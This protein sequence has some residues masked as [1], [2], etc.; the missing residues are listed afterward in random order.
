[1][2][3]TFNTNKNAP[4]I[5]AKAAAQMFKDSLHF[6][7]SI[8]KAPA[9]DYKGKNG[10]SAGDTILISKPARTVPGSSFDITSAIQDTVEE[11]V[12]LTL[13]VISTIGLAADTPDFA[14]EIDIARYVERVVR[15]A[16]N[17][18][19]H[20]V[21]SKFLN[22]ATL[23]T[24]NH[25]G[26]PG[27][28]AFTTD[29][30][31]KGRE[32]LGKF[33]CPADDNRYFLHDSTAGRKAVGERAGLF[34]QSDEIGKQYKMGYVGRAD[35]FNWMESEMLVT[36]TN[37]TDVTGVEVNATLSSQGVSAIVF[38]GVTNPGGTFTKGQV[39]TIGGVYAVHPIT[40]EKRPFLQQ[41]VVTE[42]VGTEAAATRTV[43][44]APAIYTTG[45]RKNVDAFPQADAEV[46]FVGSAGASHTQNLQYHKDA[47]RMVSVPLIMPK[48]A[49]FAAQET[50]D[51]YTVA[52]VRDWDQLTRRM[53]TRLDFLG[54][55]ASVRPEWAVR[56]TD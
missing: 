47:F 32:K 19:V 25:V 39:F 43:N 15:P 7:K 18:M 56:V 52:I 40:K 11:K 34:Q 53:V 3:N 37:G 4:G 42:D 33:L 55:I 44:F 2:A 48:K 23:A 5:I 38:K 17:D 46:T 6:G 26:I 49:E 21:E 27:Q 36:H 51:G 8:S 13:D 41:F 35:G 14:H 10:Y 50:V 30:V 12:P 31:L 22:R 9:D 24:Y 28:N 54:G 45:G 1:M 29:D 16:V 20:D